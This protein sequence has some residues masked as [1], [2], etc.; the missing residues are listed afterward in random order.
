MAQV[1][2]VLNLLH[3]LGEHHDPGA[4]AVRYSPCDGSGEGEYLLS[5][6]IEPWI[7]DPRHRFV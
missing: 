6:Q 1:E 3:N 2:R 7:L 5:G 4:A